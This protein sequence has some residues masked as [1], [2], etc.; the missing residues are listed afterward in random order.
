V[1][2]IK[3]RQNGTKNRQNPVFVPFF[4]PF[5]EN[6]MPKKI[7][8]R[9]KTTNPYNMGV[10]FSNFGKFFIKFFSVMIKLALLLVACQVHTKELKLNK[11]KFVPLK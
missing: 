6:F 5:W 4:V 8:K 10:L 1:L 9:Y 2:S 7:Q 3:T 11:S